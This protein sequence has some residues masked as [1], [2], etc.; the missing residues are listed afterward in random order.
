MMLFFIQACSV[1]NRIE[2]SMLDKN[3]IIPI[4]VEPALK[5]FKLCE[6]SCSAQIEILEGSSSKH[7]ILRISNISKRPLKFFDTKSRYFHRVMQGTV[8]PIYA[9]PIALQNQKKDNQYQEIL[10]NQYAINCGKINSQ[11]LIRLNFFSGMELG[12]DDFL[13]VEIEFEHEG[14]HQVMINYAEVLKNNEIVDQVE[15]VSTGVFRI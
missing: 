4:E 14:E 6:N 3:C 15:G 5:Q 10:K 9:F 7:R 12:P 11:F 13:D 1:H 2:I 8:K